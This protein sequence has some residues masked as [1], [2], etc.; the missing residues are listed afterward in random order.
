MT[1][2]RFFTTALSHLRLVALLSGTVLTLAGTGCTPSNN[3]GGGTGTSSAS[4]AP[5]A[6]AGG[7]GTKLVI[8]GSDTLLELAQKW[9]EE[10][11]KKNSS[12]DITVTG[13]GSGQG[14]T[15]LINGTADIAD[16]SRE[17]SEKEKTQAKDK[18]VTL[19]ETPVAR[20][21]ITI[22]VHPSNP[23]K[24]LTLEQVASIYTGKVKN[25]KDVGGPDLVITASGRDTASGTY[26][27]FQEDVLKKEEYRADMKSTPSNNAIAGNVSNEKGGIGYIGVAQAAEF[28]KEGKLKE[29]AIAFKAGEAPVLPTPETILSGK[30]PISRALYNYTRGEPEGVSKEYL[31]FVTGP[32]GQKI[33][34]EIGFVTLSKSGAAA[35]P[36]PGSAKKP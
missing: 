22:V 11:K 28:T 32:E 14:I 15:S 13:G 36:G 16:A 6:T 3:A 9:A 8:E 24:S 25:W 10:Y 4:P 20:D 31:S 33:V 23:V 1:R 30:Y 21:G 26:K 2:R 35:P 18:G 29:V 17:V 27:Y 7:G 12:V 34:E 19:V 5:E